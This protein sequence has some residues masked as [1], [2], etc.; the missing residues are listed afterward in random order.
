M[1]DQN[2]I[3]HLPADLRNSA[4]R[5]TLFGSAGL[6]AMAEER[7]QHYSREGHTND[8]DDKYDDFQ[9]T[10]AAICYA[11]QATDPP[12]LRQFNRKDIPLH[13][14]WHESSWKPAKGDSIEE[15]QRE[16]AKAGSL[17]AAEYDRLERI[18][19]RADNLAKN[20]PDGLA[21]CC[22]DCEGTGL[23][24]SVGQDDVVCGVA[25]ARCLGTGGV[26]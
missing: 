24:P 10:F 6:G 12:N 7:L 11:E 25:C 15:R 8:G 20:G 14:P 2:Q 4:G 21:N 5:P 13:W 23:V 9:L 26:R 17:I 16:L 1:N 18:R 19:V 3:A 22:R